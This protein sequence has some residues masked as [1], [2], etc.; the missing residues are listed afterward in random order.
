VFEPWYVMPTQR[1]SEEHLVLA[2]PGAIITGGM[3][4]L[5]APMAPGEYVYV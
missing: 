4:S 3:T 5:P 1:G 2:A